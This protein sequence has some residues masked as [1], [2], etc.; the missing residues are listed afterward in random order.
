MSVNT[1]KKNQKLSINVDSII[2]ADRK[3]I[4]DIMLDQIKHNR[5]WL[6]KSDRYS[7]QYWVVQLQAER[8]INNK[9]VSKNAKLILRGRSF[10]L[11]LKWAIDTAT[12]NTTYLQANLA[13]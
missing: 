10:D 13:N 8:T 12:K 2:W 4:L 1:E 11:L 5:T 9:Q 3:F 6:Y 7:A